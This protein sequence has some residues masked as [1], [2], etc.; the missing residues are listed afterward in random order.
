MQNR[1]KTRLQ[2]SMARAVRGETEAL[3]ELGIAYASGTDGV[4]IDLIEA[5]KWFNLAAQGGHE[6][7]PVMRA[8]IAWDMT[9][10][11][12]ALAQRAARAFYGMRAAA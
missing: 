5:H 1:G 11:E 4:E 12:I 8:E 9:P 3:Y 10:R 6:E 2:S 7:A